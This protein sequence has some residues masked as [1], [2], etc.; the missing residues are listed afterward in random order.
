MP[1]IA[2]CKDT[3]CQLA[4]TCYRMKANASCWQTYF[5]NSPRKNNACDYYWPMRKYDEKAKDD[6]EANLGEHFP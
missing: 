2:M 5:E 6:T 3:S 4:E 1:D